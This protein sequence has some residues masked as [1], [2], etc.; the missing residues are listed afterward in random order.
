MVRSWLGFV[1]ATVR[2]YW[3]I[4]C[5]KSELNK[6]SCTSSV[7]RLFLGCEIPLPERISA[8]C[9]GTLPHSL[10]YLGGGACAA[11]HVAWLARP[12]MINAQKNP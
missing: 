8:V 10:K 7:M 5:N 3:P 9:W 2:R 1:D 11:R 4:N 6:P 12:P